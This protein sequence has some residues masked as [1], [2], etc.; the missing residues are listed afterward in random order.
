MD[1]EKFDIGLGNS[2]STI[3]KSAKNDYISFWDECA[4]S[5]SW[6]KLWTETLQ[7][8]PPFARWFVGGQINASYNTLD[9]QI[10]RFYTIKENITTS[11]DYSFVYRHN[12]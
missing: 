7:W 4:K 10:L 2:D 5:L 3:R 8:N 1:S 6:F 12:T 11:C 9:V